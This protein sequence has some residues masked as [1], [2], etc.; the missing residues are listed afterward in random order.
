MIGV[1]GM[2]P[3]LDEDL[4][5]VVN[6]VFRVAYGTLHH[7]AW[8]LAVG[9]IIFACITGYGGKYYSKCFNTNL[10]KLMICD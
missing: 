4:V 7:L 9:W 3:F 10:I 6:P 2:V 1:Y 8:G 5:P